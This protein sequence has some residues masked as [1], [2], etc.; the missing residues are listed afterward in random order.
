MTA[1]LPA[2]PPA[3][4]P[5]GRFEWERIVR[6]I[7]MPEPVKLMA[8]VL[9]SYADPDGSRVRPSQEALAAVTGKGM[10]S[11]RRL[12]GV[13][14]DLGLIE[15]VARGGGR[16]RGGRASLYQLTLPTDLLDR[17]ELLSPGER[18]RNP[19]A[20]QMAGESTETPAIQMA[21][22]CRQ[23]PVDNSE[24]EATHTAGQSVEPEPIDRP[25]GDSSERLTGQTGSIDR[26]CR[27]TDYHPHT[28]TTKDDHPTHPDPAQ[29]QTAPTDRAPD[30]L[31]DGETSEPR[32]ASPRCEHGLVRR[33]RGDGQPT[34][35]L[36]RR[37]STR[38]PT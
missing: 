9:G 25:P 28:P 34:C 20:I 33:R 3:L 21:A 26:P 30:D 2:P 32:T 14:V 36:C 29:P 7:V 24:P 27:G 37:E 10:R 4:M 5:T 11:V 16:G 23:S 17:V 8:F 22:Q 38:E 13:L 15:Q 35:A 12:I 19:P 18:S 6:R 31:A 1:A